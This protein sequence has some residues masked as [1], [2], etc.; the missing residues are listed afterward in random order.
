MESPEKIAYPG[1]LAGIEQLGIYPMERL[2]RVDRPTT[3]IT[4]DIGRIGINDSGFRLAALGH[5][6]TVVQNQYRSNK[7]PVNASLRDMTFRFKDMVDGEIAPS[8]APL[9]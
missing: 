1:I 4:N 8:K 2:K 6:G 5:F 3:R 7:E 9:P